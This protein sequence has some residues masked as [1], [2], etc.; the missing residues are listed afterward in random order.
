MKNFKKGVAKFLVCI[1]ILATQ[2]YSPMLVRAAGDFVLN[3]VNVDVASFDVSS[4]IYLIGGVVGSHNGVYF[5]IAGTYDTYYW[6]TSTDL[7]NW[8][9]HSHSFGF[10]TDPMSRQSFRYGAISGNDMNLALGGNHYGRG[11]SRE[12][13][14]NTNFG[15]T[16]Q[17]ARLP[18][19]A[20]LRTMQFFN[21]RFWFLKPDGLWSTDGHTMRFENMPSDISTRDFSMQ[22]GVLIL[23]Y[24]HHV[25]DTLLPNIIL[26]TD[27]YN[28]HDVRTGRPDGFT[29]AERMRTHVMPGGSLILVEGGTTVDELDWDEDTW[30]QDFDNNI[31]IL[32]YDSSV[33]NP[34]FAEAARFQIDMATIE[35]EFAEFDFRVGSVT[36]GVSGN[37]LAVSLN[38]YMGRNGIDWS[39][40]WDENLRTWVNPWLEEDRSGFDNLRTAMLAY[41]G[42]TINEPGTASD[43]AQRWSIH[44]HINFHKVFTTTDMRNWNV[45]EIMNTYELDDYLQGFIMGGGRGMIQTPGSFFQF[46]RIENQTYWQ[47][48]Q[49][50]META[51]DRFILRTTDVMLPWQ[52][53]WTPLRFYAAGRLVREFGVPFDETTQAQAQ[54]APAPTP[55]APAPPAPPPPPPAPIPGVSPSFIAASYIAT[56]NTNVNLRSSPTSRPDGVN[57]SNDNVLVSISSGVQL[58]VIDRRITRAWT[59]SPTGAWH[60]GLSGWVNVRT[61]GGMAGYVYIAFL[62]F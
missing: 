7:V 8:H 55:A 21:E 19:G 47:E 62:D 33:Q 3:W 44:P 23:D 40:Y 6:V 17:Q 61:A 52:T 43:F 60:S 30:D 28:W 14:F 5:G 27:G 39:G 13:L 1:M 49:Y 26:S 29:H 56:T 18:E 58:Q 48:L 53:E 35:A 25:G 10:F 59:D 9:I 42:E 11:L 4:R 37:T 50:R 15:D 31:R 22:N 54:P 38:L 57:V 2:V 46:D 41:T 34:R 16:L 20:S 12:Y 24:V 32:R 36:S 51:D 45:S